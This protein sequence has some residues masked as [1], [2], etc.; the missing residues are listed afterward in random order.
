MVSRISQL[1]FF[2]VLMGLSSAAMLIPS[3]FGLYL[4]DFTEMRI[5]FYGSILFGFLT[6]VLGLATSGVAPSSVARSQ[7]LTLIAAYTLLPVM[8]AMPFYYSLENTTLL[9]AWFEI[10]L[11]YTSDA[12]DD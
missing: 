10:C 6:L 5:F 8:L 4:E 11:L 12:A 2:V 9:R 3:G 1:P 7:F